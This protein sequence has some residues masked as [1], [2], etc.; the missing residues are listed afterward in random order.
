LVSGKEK[1][2]EEKKESLGI[3]SYRY[4]I[5]T[6]IALNTWIM[7][8]R[9]KIRIEAENSPCPFDREA[10]PINLFF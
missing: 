1:K 4:R 10:A 3:K 7:T 2:R 9:A 8:A 5:A 6:G